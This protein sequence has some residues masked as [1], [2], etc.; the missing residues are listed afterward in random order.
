MKLEV[1]KPTW[2]SWEFNF[3]P[4]I[5]LQQF[6]KEYHLAVG[7]LCWTLSLEWQ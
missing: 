6:E 4:M 2:E 1:Y 3:L 7:W 5:L